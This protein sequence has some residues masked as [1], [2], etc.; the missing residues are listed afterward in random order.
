MCTQV[1]ALEARRE[2]DELLTESLSLLVKTS[3][4]LKTELT[5]LQARGRAPDEVLQAALSC[6]LSLR[7]RKLS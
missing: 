2:R 4:A 3:L 7:K 5:L 1:A 6:R